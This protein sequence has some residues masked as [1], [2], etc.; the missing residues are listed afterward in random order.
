MT[1]NVLMRPQKGP[2]T[3][4]INTWDDL[5]LVFYGGEICASLLSNK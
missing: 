4:F 3:S 1:E 2:Q 5:P